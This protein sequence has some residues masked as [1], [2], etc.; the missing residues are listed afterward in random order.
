[1]T[2]SN[3]YEWLDRIDRLL[4]ELR[5]IELW[6]AVYWQKVH[7]DGYETVAFVTRKNRRHEIVSQLLSEIARLDRETEPWTVKRSG[8]AGENGRSG[9]ASS[10]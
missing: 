6:D 8:N 7:P 2:L 10:G 1:M 3:N 9:R 5:A 4:S